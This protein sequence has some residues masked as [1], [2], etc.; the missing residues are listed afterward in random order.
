MSLFKIIE[1][2]NKAIKFI[3][4]RRAAENVCGGLL[5]HSACTAQ[6][7][8]FSHLVIFFFL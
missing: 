1:G 7:F 3:F 8:G 2:E 5:H 4:Y 6:G